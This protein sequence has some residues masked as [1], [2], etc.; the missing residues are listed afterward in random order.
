[1]NLPISHCPFLCCVETL[2][3]A[4]NA[5]I[6]YL[7]DKHLKTEALPPIVGENVDIEGRE[8]R[9]VRG[10]HLKDFTVNFKFITLT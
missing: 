1:M 10:C 2:K 8:K 3:T 4:A 7:S 6:V 9:A 5:T